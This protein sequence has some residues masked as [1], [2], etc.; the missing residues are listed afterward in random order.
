MLGHSGMLDRSLWSANIM[1]DENYM[2]KVSDFAVAK[3]LPG[4]KCDDYLANDNTRIPICW[5][6]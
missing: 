3:V 4:D 2:L 6:W 5:I 1:V